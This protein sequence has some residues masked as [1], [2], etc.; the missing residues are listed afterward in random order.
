[1]K[2]QD[3]IST[4]LDTASARLGGI[5][6]IAVAV[7]LAI[8]LPGLAAAQ[9]GE[10]FAS[11]HILVKPRTLV[12]A[13][14]F[15]AVLAR[16]GAKDQSRIHATTVHLVTVAPGLEQTLVQQFTREPD[17]EFAELDRQVDI[18]TTTANDPYYNSAWHLQTIG[19]PTAWDTAKGNG[20]T[21]A[22]LDTGVDS[23]HPDLQGKLVPGWNV[24]DNT[25]NTADIYGHGTEVA[26]VIGAVSN[27][28]IGVTSVAWNTMIMPVRVTDDSSTG[29]AYISSIANGVTWAADHGANIANASYATLYSSPT[30][31]NAGNYMLSKGGLLVVAAGNS[32]TM[33]SSPNTA[34]MIPVS[35]T[36]SSDALTSWSSY[37][38]Y[39]DV[40]APGAGIWTTTMG[41]GYAAVSGT[42]FSSPMTA[43]VLALEKS[44]NTAL[45]NTQLQSILE[46]TAVD[47]GTPGYDQYYGYGRINAAAAVAAA[48][49]AASNTTTV[50]TQAPTTS[51]ASPTGG[52]VSGT[53]T[54]TVNATD[55]VG[56]T[57]VDLYAGSTLVGSVSTAPY[58]FTWN[59]TSVVNGSVNLVAYAYDAAGNK[60]TSSAVTVTVSNVA[61]T[62]P[63]T[64]SILN[65]GAGSTV[66]GMVSIK[67]SASDNVGVTSLTLYIDG[68]L[69]SST[70]TGS[71]SY[72]WNTRRVSKGTHTISAMAQ[73]ASGNT[74]TQSI[75]VTH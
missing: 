39:V 74:S 45:S 65:P 36:D 69:K 38:P 4:A 64:V 37:G 60:G 61:D 11:G 49:A 19:A 55:N 2:I 59:T 21:V 52:T 25:S 12:T 70:N 50:D 43:A 27:N 10:R 62:T 23:T 46:S 71:L 63:P 56:V 51:I 54:V 57:R 75:S 30:M 1:M 6:Q 40:A 7:L 41:G 73:D 9:A 66:G 53:V 44:A 28:G 16:H 26:G 17:V 22:V 35:A 24:V 31:Q 18:N 8:L 47:L 29:S 34:S 67:V 68:V 5:R 33:D 13:T 32:G 14:Q 58:S 72:S 15:A 3:L 42:S 20:V 48:V